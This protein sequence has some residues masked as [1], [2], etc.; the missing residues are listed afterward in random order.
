MVHSVN[1]PLVLEHYAMM[2]DFKN[3]GKNV[4]EDDEIYDYDELQTTAFDSKSIDGGS[5]K[6]FSI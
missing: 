4:F 2:G 6:I 5:I 3:I 1:R